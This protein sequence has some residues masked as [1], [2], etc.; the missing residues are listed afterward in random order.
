MIARYL[1]TRF[2]KY[3][4]DVGAIFISFLGAHYLINYPPQEQLV[5]DIVFLFFYNTDYTKIVFFNLPNN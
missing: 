5:T 1:P 4:Y 3:I 2:I